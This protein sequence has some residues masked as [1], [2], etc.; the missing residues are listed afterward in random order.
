MQKEKEY[1]YLIDYKYSSVTSDEKLIQR[2]KKQLEL[3]AYAVEKVLK[4]KVVKK[5]P[6]TKYTSEK[7]RKKNYT[8][9]VICLLITI[10]ILLATYSILGFELTLAVGALLA[11]LWF[12]VFL[13]SRIKSRKK[14][15]K[16]VQ[17]I[18]WTYWY[19][20]R[21]HSRT[22]TSQKCIKSCFP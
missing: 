4:K 17:G 1:A 5:N 19:T 8:T 16:I 2:Y 20:H 10:A 18:R 14:R 15:R 11:V 3:Y 21:S 12:F 9:A 7:P 6:E 22:W 13:L